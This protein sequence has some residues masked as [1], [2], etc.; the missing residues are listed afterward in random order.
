[1]AF[2]EIAKRLSIPEATA[3]YRVQRLLNSDL[4]KIV[5]WPNPDKLGKPHVLIIW[6]IV[7]NQ[8]VDAVAAELAAMQEV[9]FAAIAAAGRYNIVVDVYFG[10][11][12]QLLDFF[13]KLHQVEGVIHYESQFIL[14]LLKAE[15]DHVV[16][17]ET[18][19]L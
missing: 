3:R 16:N 15:Y 18:S 1:M 14:K 17:Y 12:E 13:K 2:T 8:R 11:H 7:E 10:S 5:A 19:S 4:I 6:L 9:R